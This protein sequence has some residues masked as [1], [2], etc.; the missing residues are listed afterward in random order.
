MLSPSA[1]FI[2]SVVEGLRMTTPGG[3]ISRRMIKKSFNP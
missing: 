3:G 2:L 1:E